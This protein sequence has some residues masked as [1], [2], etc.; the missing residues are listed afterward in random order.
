M[1]NP[2]ILLGATATL[3]LA[4]NVDWSDLSMPEQVKVATTPGLYLPLTKNL[5]SGEFEKYSPEKLINDK[6]SPGKV[7]EMIGNN[8]SGI[9][10]STYKDPSDPDAAL[11]YLLR[12]PLAEMPYDLSQYMASLEIE[13][14]S[15]SLNVGNGIS[16]PPPGTPLPSPI[17]FPSV[18]VDIRDMANLVSSL[19]YTEFGIKIAGNFERGMEVHITDSNAPA[20][21]GFDLTS[22]GVYKSDGYTHFVKSNGTWKPSKSYASLIIIDMTLTHYPNAPVDSS[23]NITIQPEFILDWTEVIVNP[24]DI[25]K[26]EGELPLDFFELGQTLNGITFPAGSV[27]AYLYTSG[28]PQSTAAITLKSIT[29]TPS[30]VMHTLVDQAPLRESNAPELPSDG[31]PYMEP[32]PPS[33]LTDPPPLGAIDLT[34]TLNSSLS[35]EVKLSYIVEMGQIT[36]NNGDRNGAISA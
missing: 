32:I 12:Y 30:S 23:G 17:P 14:P 3:F 6:L 25:E 10:V 8:M 16:A 5:F 22:T 20:N 33:S 4:C 34:D 19:T 24:G 29:I 28:L 13:A 21:G 15:I 9:T 35:G 36:L 26:L 11:T 2:L 18:N 31:S 1:K 27:E 7:K